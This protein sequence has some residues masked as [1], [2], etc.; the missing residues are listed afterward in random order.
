MRA[1]APATSVLHMIQESLLDRLLQRLQPLRLGLA[2]AG[3]GDQ[4]VRQVVGVAVGV[5][6]FEALEE[7]ELALAAAAP[8]DVV[9]AGG[10]EGG[11]QDLAVPEELVAPPPEGAV[12]GE[13]RL[14]LLR[15]L[16]VQPVVAPPNPVEVGGRQADPGAGEEHPV[17]LEEE[18]ERVR[19]LQV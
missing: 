1:S 15:G 9:E 14:P 17:G 18:A 19:D 5:V 13:R 4:D 7:G 8:A 12:D 16:A 10:G 3:F 6:P 2:L 11:F